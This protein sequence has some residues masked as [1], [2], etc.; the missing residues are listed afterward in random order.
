MIKGVQKFV[1][2]AVAQLKVADLTAKVKRSADG[3]DYN[4]VGNQII[5]TKKGAK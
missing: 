3:Y 5:R 2:K 1:N 4:R